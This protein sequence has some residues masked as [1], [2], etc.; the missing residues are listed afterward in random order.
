MFR[1]KCHL[2]FK[3]INLVV[4]FLLSCAVS[5]GSNESDFF[6]SVIN[7]GQGL[8]Q[9][10]IFDSTS[11]VIWDMGPPQAFDSWFSEYSRLGKPY[12][13]A[14]IISHRDLDHSG[15]LLFI[16]TAVNWSGLLVTS[17]Y[18][19]TSYIKKLC[20]KWNG[21]VF[22]K[23]YSQ[24]DTF[25]LTKD[26]KV[27]CLWPP[28]DL[29]FLGIPTGEDINRYSL[30]FSI[31][32]EL[33]RFLILSDIDSIASEQIAL[34]YKESLNSQILVL[35]HHGSKSAFNYLFA[36]YAR[37]QLAIVS[38]ARYNDYGHPSNSVLALYSM[39]GSQL[40]STFTLGSVTITSNG[41]VWQ[42]E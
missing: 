9:I 13:D 18:E 3:V 1:Q 27:R 4:S 34:K 15:G 20:E 7:V 19:D 30:V 14:I 21:S 22:V 42:S 36:G 37:P 24:G 41:F 35:P 11:A 31:Q 26:V 17:I 2:F 6:F 25:A 32:H 10:G 8:S 39:L 23:T 38:C 16:D 5:T 28:P 40:I 29:E 12:I 33:V